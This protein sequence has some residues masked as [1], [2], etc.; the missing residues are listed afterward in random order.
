MEIALG[1]LPGG[2]FYMTFQANLPPQFWPMKGQCSPRILDEL[3]ALSAIV[4]R[5]EYN[6]VLINTFAEDYS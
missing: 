2:P 4:I 1:R 5:E 3:L 6:C